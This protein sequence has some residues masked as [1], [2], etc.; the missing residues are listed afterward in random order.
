MAL[1]LLLIVSM[2]HI[3]AASNSSRVLVY[4]EAFPLIPDGKER[5][6]CAEETVIRNG[7]QTVTLQYNFSQRS[8][9]Q[10]HQTN[11]VTTHTIDQPYL[12]P[13]PSW[14]QT[15]KDQLVNFL[16]NPFAV[17]A[18]LCVGYVLY[19]IKSK[20]SLYSLGKA[21]IEKAIWSLWKSKTDEL[22]FESQDAETELLIEILNT[23]NTQN[24]TTAVARFLK[25]VE[26][27]SEL[28][29]AFIDQAQAI[30]NSVMHYIFEDLTERIK[31]AQERLEQVT[32]NKQIVLRWLSPKKTLELERSPA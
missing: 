5:I 7:N 1:V 26:E 18:T 3:S 27:E 11:N 17:G 2:I 21:C 16:W 25:D 10:N 29:Q 31:Q 6:I 22:T 28:L 15:C 14:S 9:I 30:Q 4:E 19:C 32:H 12:A 20:F 8:L 23:Y 24:Y 13:Q